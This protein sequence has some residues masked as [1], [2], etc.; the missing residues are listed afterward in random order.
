MDPQLEGALEKASLFLEESPQLFAD[1]ELA[2]IKEIVQDVP[3]YGYKKS[4]WHQQDLDDFED[5]AR[6]LH[7]KDQM[8]K[9]VLEAFLLIFNYV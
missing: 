5:K 7:G 1:W 8:P 3:R 2:D 6:E 4:G 9:E